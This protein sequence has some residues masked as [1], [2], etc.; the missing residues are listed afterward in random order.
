MDVVRVVLIG[1][2]TICQRYFGLQ[3]DAMFIAV[4]GSN[5]SVTRHFTRQSWKMLFGGRIGCLF[6]VVLR[7]FR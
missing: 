1:N 2:V 3:R 7:R 4:I 5:Q 6:E